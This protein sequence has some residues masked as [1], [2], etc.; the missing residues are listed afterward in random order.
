M[1]PRV[2][3]RPLPIDD[4]IHCRCIGIDALVFKD[5][6]SATN[7]L[8]FTEASCSDELATA[9]SAENVRRSAFAIA[10]AKRR[11]QVLLDLVLRA[12]GLGWAIP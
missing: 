2:A 1:E 8:T 11:E 9:S 7:S 10:N 5:V 12:L 6:M 4:S 3:P